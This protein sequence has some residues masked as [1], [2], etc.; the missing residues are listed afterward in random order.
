MTVIFGERKRGLLALTP[1]NRTE[2]LDQGQ[3]PPFF[4]HMHA[5]LRRRGT[6]ASC[7]FFFLRLPQTS[8]HNEILQAIKIF[9]N[10]SYKKIQSFLNVFFNFNV[11]M[12]SGFEQH[13]RMEF[14]NIW[15]SKPWPSY[16]PSLENVCPWTV[17]ASWKWN[18]GDMT[19]V[20]AHAPEKYG[21]AACVGFMQST[22]IKKSPYIEPWKG[23]EC[24]ETTLISKLN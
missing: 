10:V 16:I 19:S 24:N 21:A 12:S 11:H 6:E 4:Q 18:I 3:V 15:R 20:P 23:Q 5:N 17:V 8:F 14:T 1:S 22:A 2:A 7:F 13:F 9:V